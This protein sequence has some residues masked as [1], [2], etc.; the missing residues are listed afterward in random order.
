MSSFLHGICISEASLEI[1]CI[2]IPSPPCF[3]IAFYWYLFLLDPA[4]LAVVKPMLLDWWFSES[5]EG[6]ITQRSVGPT[7]RLSQWVSLRWGLWVC[8]GGN[9]AG[10]R[11]ELWELLSRAKVTIL[12]FFFCKGTNDKY[13]RVGG[14]DFLFCNY[15]ILSFSMNTAKDNL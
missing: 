2:H 13:F 3:L 10:L 12:F 5:P 1:L 15:S 11:T 9:A 6:L 7:P 8:N 4:C 14:P